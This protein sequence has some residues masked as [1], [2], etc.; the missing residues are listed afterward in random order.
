MGRVG[1]VL[2]LLRVSRH[3]PLLLL[4]TAVVL[5]VRGIDV[6]IVGGA[7]DAVNAGSVVENAIAVTAMVVGVSADGAGI[8]ATGVAIGSVGV[9]GVIVDR[10]SVV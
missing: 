1:P 4:S 9:V 2:P 8:A 3:L 7:S 6:G 5:R 10:K